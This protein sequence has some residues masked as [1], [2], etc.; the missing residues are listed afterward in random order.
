MTASPI[1][2]IIFDCD[3]VLVDS[4]LIASRV[5]SE[6]LAPLGI[7]LT[8]AQCRARFTGISLSAVRTILEDETGISL[9]R[10]F[11]ETLRRRD[12]EAF[13]RE[14]RPIRGIG[15]A[16]RACPYPKC[17]ASSGSLEKIRH[18]LTLTGLIDQFQEHLFSAQQVAHGKPAP[19]LFLFACETMS[20]I[21]GRTVVIEDSIAGV[22]AAGAA[23]M[24]VL[25]FT[26]GAHIAPGD[27]DRLRNAGA[28]DVFSDMT[29][30]I[31]ALTAV[32][33][34]LNT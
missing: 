7:A 24:R 31:P 3:G 16:L 28:C 19:D 32:G 13:T 26:G 22:R 2:L 25:G 14:L 12:I 10:D 29:Q 20:A 5:L 1:D 6:T 15:D 33:A 9:P 27:D 30:L 11:E 23:G 18:S 17:V 8:P 4:E 34:K 21:P